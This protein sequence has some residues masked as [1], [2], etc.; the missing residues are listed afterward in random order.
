MR[1]LVKVRF[2]S[3]GFQKIA[4]GGAGAGA[5]PPLLMHHQKQ[6]RPSKVTLPSESKIMSWRSGS[7]PLYGGHSKSTLVPEMW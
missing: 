5:P 3:K 4:G 1:M 7:L 2:R 6:G